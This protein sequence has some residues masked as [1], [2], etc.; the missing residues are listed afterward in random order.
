MSKNCRKMPDLPFIPWERY[1]LRPMN[2]PLNGVNPM[3][4]PL[5]AVYPKIHHRIA[6]VHHNPSPFIGENPT[7]IRPNTEALHPK[8][9][10]RR[11]VRHHRRADL[12]FNGANPMMIRQNTA[13]MHPRLH[14]HNRVR[15]LHS[16]CEN[17]MTMPPNM[18]VLHPKC[19]PPPLACRR[20]IRRDRKPII[21][22][23]Q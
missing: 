3:M 12:P 6:C 16:S 14:H 19:I 13:I 10:R 5:L 21:R 23:G 18:G 1:L 22:N 2:Q 7:T 11:L 8:C 4:M 15:R 20:P 17:P 9:I